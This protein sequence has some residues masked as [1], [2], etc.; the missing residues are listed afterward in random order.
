MPVVA[1]VGGLADTVIDANDAALKAGVATGIQFGEVTVDG[2]IDAVRRTV[3]LYR[4]PQAWR[5]LQAMGMRADVGWSQS[6]S[7][8]ATLYRSLVRSTRTEDIR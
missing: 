2:L 1:R 3:G 8:Y 5:S 7:E 4:R 6:A